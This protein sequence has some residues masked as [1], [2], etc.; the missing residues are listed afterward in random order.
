MSRF[1]LVVPPLAAHITPASAVAAELVDRGHEVAWAGQPAAL[2]GLVAADHPVFPCAGVPGIDDRP[3]DL[4]GV[5]A[6][7]FRW[8]EFFAPLAYAMAPGVT[9]AVMEFGPDLLVVD[10]QT[11]AGALVAERL[12]VPYVTS[13][14]TSTELSAGPV[15]TPSPGRSNASDPSGPSD[16]SDP[17][18]GSDPSDPWITDLLDGLRL[19]LGDPSARYDPRFSPRLTLVFSTSEFTG[20]QPPGRGPVRFV[21]PALGRLPDSRADTTDF[22]WGWVD[23]DDGRALVLVCLDTA[24]TTMGA[25]FLAQC[26]DGVRARARELRAVVVDPDGVLGPPRDDDNLL[27]C[28]EVPQLALLA[29]TDALVCHAGHNTVTEALWHG[30]PLVVAPVR[31]DQPVVAARVTTVGAGVRVRFGRTD[32]KA[33]GCAL[34]AVLGQ[35]HFAAAARRVGHSFREAGGAPAAAAHLEAL[36]IA[37]QEN[38]RHGLQI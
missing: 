13:S 34:D 21:G 9:A 29:H 37:E 4:R 14:T 27:I 19:R 3:R 20:P 17:A 33:V 12:G 16:S 36:A 26:V 32:A 1:L 2:E 5:A 22:P 28:T 31:D 35:P 15:G 30:V 18:Y 11:V 10:Q 25:H 38:P 7:R 8:D 24:D 23:R 6:L